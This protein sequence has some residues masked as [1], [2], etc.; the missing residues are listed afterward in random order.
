MKCAGFH[1]GLFLG[2]SFWIAAPARAQGFPPAEA[3]A[4]MTV[5]DGLT[6]RLF[7]AEPLVQQPVAIEFDDRGRLWVIQYMQY[8][9]PAGLQRVSVDRYS[10]TAYDKIPEPPPRGPKG[11]DRIT[12]LEDSDGDG[13]ADRSH[14]FLSEL[15]LASGLAFGHGGVFV[16][17][18]PYLLFY[19]DRDRNDQ[20]DGDPEVLLTGFGMEDAHSVANS[21]TWGPDGWLYGCQGSTVTAKIRGIEFQQGVWRYHPPSRRFELFC[22]G[23]GNMWGLDFD[24]NGHL[25]TST[26]YGG[27]VTL[28]GVQ[29]GYYWKLFGKHGPLH[30][31]YTFGYFDHVPHEGIQGGHVSNGGLFYEADTFPAQWRGRYISNDLLDHSIRWSEIQPRG[32]TFRGRQGGDVLRANDTWFAPSDLTLGPDGALYAADWHDKRTA[33]PDPDADWDRSNGRIYRIAPPK[34]EPAN[35]PDLAT[36]S[37]DKLIALRSHPNSWY[38]RRARRLLGERQAKD[39]LDPLHDEVRSSRGTVALE[40]LWILHVCKAI[41]PELAERLLEHPDAEVRAW[42]VRLIGDEPQV[43]PGLSERLVALATQ[44]PSVLVRAQLACTAQRLP[45]NAG[46]NV[47]ERLLLRD[48]NQDRDDPYVPLLLWWAVERHATAAVDSVVSRF[49]TPEAWRSGLIRTEIMGRLIRRFAS[50]GNEACDLA[51]VKLLTAAPTAEARRSLGADLEEST[52]GRP[53]QAIAPS[54]VAVATQLADANPADVPLNRLAFRLGSRT[55]MDRVRA[56]V[57]DERGSDATR[58]LLIDVLGETGDRPSTD[59]LLGLATAGNSAPVQVAALKALGRFE[60]ESIAKALIDAYPKQGNDWRSRTRELLLGRPSWARAYLAA[61][62]R[63]Q[64][65]AKEASIEQIGR[66]ALLQDPGL[67]ELVRKHWGSVKGATP[68]EKLAE[69]RRLNNDLRAAVGDPKRGTQLFKD[70]CSSCHRLFDQGTAIGP[71]LTFAN[72]RD[73]EFLLVSLVDPSGVVRK[74]YQSYIAQTRDGRVLTG[75]IVEQTPDAITLRDAKGEPTRIPRADV[76]ALKESTASLMPESLY[77]EFTPSQ[78]RDLFS[79][80]QGDGPA[81]N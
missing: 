13:Q 57:S 40:A 9:N 2:F 6:V 46:L 4:K 28:H 72:R 74:E 16:L 1:A 52:R 41:T 43:T 70:R 17:Q 77:K 23:G 27:F 78:I 24:R 3:A 76:E 61:I 7:A 69:V 71:D 45:A 31:P 32:S 21:L 37:N 80:L 55:A 18:S 54:L 66:V 49:S 15:N 36:L 53:A 60:D 35:G 58:V 11:S 30:N 63:G 50:E 75:L 22:E 39:G 68:G 42:M 79:Y 14:D 59:R 62:D 26:N 34:A 47:A 20:P 29:G 8:P 51:C 12:I 81:N 38:R 44:E 33:H 48:L 67:D 19:P 73:R 64:L 25:F 56:L 5:A 65:S 10:R